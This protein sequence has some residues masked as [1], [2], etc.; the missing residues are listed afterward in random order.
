VPV[1][2]QFNAAAPVDTSVRHT[3]YDSISLWG[4]GGRGGYGEGMEAKGAW[5]ECWE[6]TPCASQQ[7]GQAEAAWVCTAHTRDF[8][9]G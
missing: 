8:W 4:G 9:L 3:R 5:H 2:E 1:L 6:E 7:L